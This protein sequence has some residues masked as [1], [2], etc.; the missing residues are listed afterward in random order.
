MINR[1]GLSVSTGYIKLKFKLVMEKATMKWDLILV[2]YG[3]IGLKSNYVRRQL[4]EKLKSH[5]KKS[6]EIEGV[7]EYKIESPRGRV[8]L[9]TPSIEKSINALS[10]VPGIVSYSPCKTV[11]PEVASIVDMAMQ[12]SQD[13]LA[14][15][16]SFAVDA[17]RVGEHEFT[18][19]DLKE[20]VGKELR[21]ESGASVNLDDP[22]YTLTIEV[23]EDTAYLFT[24]VYSGLGGLPYGVQG[25]LISLFS[26]GMD[27]PVATALMIK[28]G[29]D[30]IALYIDKGG[31]GS[32]KERERA[33]KVAEKLSRL[34][35]EGLKFIKLDFEGIYSAIKDDADK[36]TCILCKRAMYKAGERI[37]EIE[38]AKGLI[39]GES[40]GQ[41]ASQ[42]LDN[43]MTLDESTSIPVYRPLIG[44]D[45][46][47]TQKISMRLGT[48]QA[49]KE[50]V[51]GC[52]ILP[53]RVATVSDPMQIKETENK[54]K[55]DEE[56]EK[57]VENRE[58]DLIKPD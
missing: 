46:S 40:V 49:S 21:V 31:F 1:V 19:Q 42:T 50:D 6:I 27:S 45:K 37:N 29:C 54:I 2:R 8:F 5:I 30:P 28:R 35:P 55:I 23:R 33:V 57:T 41:V 7:E 34:T 20:I 4:I 15:N 38:G 14:E 58:V 48:Y 3:E 56:I 18:S 36:E 39:T 26:G 32:K 52:P 9:E 12:I 11:E 43:L 47:Q 16:M 44:F 13:R 17:R 24:D 22:D 25:K 51:G 53:E 10:Y